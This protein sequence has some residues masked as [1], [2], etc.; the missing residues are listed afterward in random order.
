FLVVSMGESPTGDQRYTHRCEVA[1]QRHAERGSMLVW[2]ARGRLTL[3]RESPA[4]TSPTQR[5]AADGADRNHAGQRADALPHLRAKLLM[6]G[7]TIVEILLRQRDFHHQHV[8]C[9]EPRV[10]AKQP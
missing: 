6:V 3:D 9:I 8:S 7:R 2:T 5:K 1:G 4:S 10:H